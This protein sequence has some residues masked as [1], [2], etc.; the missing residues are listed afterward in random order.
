MGQFIW[1]IGYMEVSVIKILIIADDFTGAL[2]TGVQFSKKGIST[3]VSTKTGID[4]KEIDESIQVLV[5]DTESR[6]DKPAAA[7]GKVFYLTGKAREYGVRHIYKK[8]DSTLRGNIGAELQAVVDAYDGE[9]LM[10]VPAYPDT[11]RTTSKGIQFVNGI[12]LSE[13]V[14]SKDPLNP[15]KTSSVSEI[16]AETADLNLKEVNLSDDDSIS[17]EKKNTVYIFDA[18]NNGDMVKVGKI[19][20]A[21]GKFTLTAGCAGFA[22]ILREH[23]GL[24]TEEKK[25]P[26]SNGS[27]LIICG[28]VNENSIRQARYA[29]K[30]GIRN[31]TLTPEQKMDVG[32]WEGFQ[33]KELAAEMIRELKKNGKLLVKTVN[34]RE[35]AKDTDDPEVI[36]HNMGKLTK[37]ILEGF[38]PDALIVFGGDTAIGIMDEIGC[39]GLKPMDEIMPGVPVSVIGCSGKDITLVSKAGGFGEENVLEKILEYL[40][41]G[42]K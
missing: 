37:I 42:G 28:S 35:E 24:I 20:A 10:F 25:H 16:I 9:S 3:L 34:S 15:V 17:I 32:Y 1:H 40:K 11:G 21:K 22:E 23:A 13:T 4:F 31:I 6:H 14:F 26:V 41:K 8:T 29:G 39:L 19:F 38:L 30:M 33:G 36:A 27:T 12:R 5:V 2:D 18:E 7:Y